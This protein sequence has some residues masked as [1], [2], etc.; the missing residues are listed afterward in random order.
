MRDFISGPAC[1]RLA[2]TGLTL[3]L[4]AC[5]APAVAQ[6]ITK[7]LQGGGP[8][9]AQRQ[10]QVNSWIVTVAAS[11]DDASM[12]FADELG[13]VLNDGDD[14]RVLPVAARGPAG[15]VEDLL[16]LHDIDL[17]LTQADVLEYFRTERKTTLD[18]RIQYIAR[19]PAAELH[20]AAPESIRSLEELRG[21][22]V[23]FGPPGSAAA[24]TGPLAFRRLGIAVKPVF[25]DLPAGIGLVKSG[26][27]AALL[28]VDAKPSDFWLRVPPYAGLHFLPV[29]HAKA[30]ADLYPAVALTSAD[31][32]NLIGP[33]ERVDTI[34]VPGVVAVQNMPKTDDRFRRVLRFV[35]YL[36]ARWDRLGGSTFYPGWREVSL[37]TTVPGWTR[38]SPSEVFR[39]FILW[40][41]QQ[42]SRRAP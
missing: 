27:A 16:N 33:D 1:F 21:H 34:A 35:Q 38:F 3:A 22:K 8:E 9:E 26:E 30:L 10:R 25:I 5:T 42:Y 15:N 41:D 20:V 24:V 37:A 29:P 13:R 19:L 36:S 18:N 28:T 4:S 23:V 2:L 39:Q 11:R 32:P 7:S 31:Y 17:A 14:L 6:Q 40:R 12:R